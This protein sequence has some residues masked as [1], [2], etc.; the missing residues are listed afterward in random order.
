MRNASCCKGVRVGDGPSRIHFR[1]YRYVFKGYY[2]GRSSMFGTNLV[3]GVSG[4][5]HQ[6]FRLIRPSCC[7]ID[8]DLPL[9]LGGVSPTCRT[10]TLSSGNRSA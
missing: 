1:S 2:S 3:L 6:A 8:V 5:V 4:Y 10:V 7:S 9:H